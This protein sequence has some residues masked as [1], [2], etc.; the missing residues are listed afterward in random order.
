MNLSGDRF[1]DEMRLA[2][3][4]RR[5]SLRLS[6]QEVADRM[7]NTQAGVSELER[8]ESTPRIETLRRWVSAL[9]CTLWL[10]IRVPSE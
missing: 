7:G 6:Q 1:T 3:I 4:A 8:R 2:L 5:K 9:D 10:D